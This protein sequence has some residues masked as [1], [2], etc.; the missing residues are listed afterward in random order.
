[1]SGWW[2]VALVERADGTGAGAGTGTGAAV[3]RARDR[4]LHLR[5]A[6]RLRWQEQLAPRVRAAIVPGAL[7]QVR[8]RARE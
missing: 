2:V 7:E 6:A 1:M 5:A 3:R 4:Y 8:V